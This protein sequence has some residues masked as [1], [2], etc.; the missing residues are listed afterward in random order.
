MPERPNNVGTVNPDSRGVITMT[1]GI[2]K[3]QANTTL[4]LRAEQAVGPIRELAAQMAEMSEEARPLHERLSASG[5]LREYDVI[6]TL[7]VLSQA[8]AAKS[9]G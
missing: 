7:S 9:S 6:L 1:S 2:T 5:T 3:L 8:V 4:A